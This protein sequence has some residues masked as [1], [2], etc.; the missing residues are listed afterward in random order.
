[1]KDNRGGR[2]EGAG[3]KK[4]FAEKCTVTVSLDKAL[5]DAID[6]QRGAKPRSRYIMEAV[7]GVVGLTPPV[8]LGEG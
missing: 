1:M 3:R 2:R 4:M 6:A 7:A 8:L 5:L